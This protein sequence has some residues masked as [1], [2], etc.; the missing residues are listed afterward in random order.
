MPTNRGLQYAIL[1]C[2]LA[3]LVY[4]AV[5]LFSGSETEQHRRRQAVVVDDPKDDD[6]SDATG[7]GIRRRWH[8]APLPKAT[9]VRLRAKA[10]EPPSTDPAAKASRI[11]AMAQLAEQED[12]ES[13]DSLIELMED[14]D[15]EIRA[16][17]ARAVYRII[18]VELLFNADDSL[19]KRT[20]VLHK[21]QRLWKY[22][23]EHR[24]AGYLER[25]RASELRRAHQGK[26]N[27]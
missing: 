17:S 2:G 27:H 10:L 7:T 1:C 6:P 4:F 21:T 18:K 20:E 22:I 8:A 9:V 23:K 13:V 11:D 15:V 16:A 25:K 14:D 5:S 12:F 26:Q 24:L 3:A 19:A